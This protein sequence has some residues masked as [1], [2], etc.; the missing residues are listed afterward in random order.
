MAYSSDVIEL[1]A[2]RLVIE[3]STGERVS[4]VGYVLAQDLWTSVVGTQGAAIA[5][6]GCRRSGETTRSYT[7]G[8]RRSKV[9]QFTRALQS[10]R[11]PP[12]VQTGAARSR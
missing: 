3:K 8:P 11:L 9:H 10:L 5:K 12:G 2:Q 1:S 4:E 6:S 7:Q